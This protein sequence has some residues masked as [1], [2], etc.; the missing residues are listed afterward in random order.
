MNRTRS[1][2]LLGVAAGLTAC[3]GGETNQA[4]NVAAGNDGMAMNT[5]AANEALAVDM[6]NVAIENETIDEAPPTVTRD[7]DE[8]PAVAPRT[9]PPPPPPPPKADSR[10][11]APAKTSPKEP[12]SKDDPHAGHDMNNMSH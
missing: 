10:P 3:G 1:F 8:A 2:L 6:N 4:A 7:A 11:K 12:V 9:P 5:L